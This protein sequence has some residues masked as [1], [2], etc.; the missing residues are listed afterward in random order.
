MATSNGMLTA[1]II[2]CTGK[3]TTVER[4]KL[5]WR[6][7]VRVD[8]RCQAFFNPASAPLLAPCWDPLL[9]T[10]NSHCV[11]RSSSQ[12]N[13]EVME[14]VNQQARNRGQAS[15]E[16]VDLVS[17]F[18][19]F[20]LLHRRQKNQVHSDDQL[21]RRCPTCTSRRTGFSQSWPLHSYHAQPRHHHFFTSESTLSRLV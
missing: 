17:S 19:Y 5:Q 18:I 15:L 6:E 16:M 20:F 4:G 2:A 13:L 21:P 9:T 1:A 3:E 11:T 7:E 8:G 12:H 14:T 10:N